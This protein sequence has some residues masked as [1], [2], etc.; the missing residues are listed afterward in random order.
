MKDAALRRSNKRV[1][2]SL[3]GKP[4]PKLDP[5]EVTIRELLI[6]LEQSIPALEY[7]VRM[8]EPSPEAYHWAGTEPEDDISHRTIRRYE[9]AK[10]RLKNAKLAIYHAKVG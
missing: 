2:K 3:G 6:A 7:K 4:S 8:L 9:E 1:L 5:A 10:Q